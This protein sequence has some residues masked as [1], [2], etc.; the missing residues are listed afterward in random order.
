MAENKELSVPGQDNRL[1]TLSMTDTEAG[2]IEK[3]E[4]EKSIESPPARSRSVSPER[5]ETNEKDLERGLAPPAQDNVS[6]SS[7]SSPPKDMKSISP[8]QSALSRIASSDYPKNFALG[9]IVLALFCSMFLVALDMT[10]I[11]TAIPEITDQFHSL[12]DIGWYGSAFFLTLAAFQSSWGKAYKYFNLKWTFLTSI[13]IFE[14]GSLICAVAKDSKTLIVGRAIAGMGGAGVSSGAYT[15]IGFSAPPKM[16]PAYTGILG[17]GYGVASVLGPLIGGVFTDHISWRWC[18]YINLPLGGAAVA[19]I[20]IFFTTPAAARPV[21]ASV[22]EKVKQMD[23]PGIITILGGTTCYVLAMQWGGVTKPW[24]D[25]TVIG[26]LVGFGVLFILYAVIQYVSGD[27][28]SIPPRLIKQRAI[29]TFC[30]FIF[31]NA[32]AY[33][34]LLYYLPLYFQSTRGVSPSSSGVRNLPFVFGSAI[35]TVVSG[36]LITVKGHY[37]PILIF[38]SALATVA[39]GLIY[40]F[41]VNTSAGKWIGYQILS[42]AG[43]GLTIQIPV[44]VAQ[45]T[46]TPSDLSSASSIILFFMTMGGAIFISGAQAGFAN[47]LLKSVPTKAPGIPPEQ[48]VVTG[49]SELRK[50][51]K[52]EVLP[53]I[54]ASYMDGL[55]VAYALTIALVGMSFLVAFTPKWQ[56][57]RGKVQ[58]GGGAA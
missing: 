55:K 13:G 50:V 43:Q 12:D 19:I 57:I 26:T 38:G 51:F 2:D 30:V 34:V 7:R 20:L 3:K 49:A 53:G 32:A 29:W 8:K 17:V 14:I 10:I 42:G 11:G 33:F 9:M 28:G 58:P 1:S 37:M 22:L 25:S 48:V 4:I 6:V 5:T 40:T 56:S 31:F 16:R 24:S 52:P 46:V 47:K 27:Y 35:F 44:I 23:I 15:I 18:F 21:K 41:D 45:A 39:A 54:I 36:G